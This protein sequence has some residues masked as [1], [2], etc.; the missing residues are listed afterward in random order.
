[1]LTGRQFNR[2]YSGR[3]YKFT[4][5]LENHNGIQYKS[6]LNHD[7]LDFDPS[8]R[9]QPG[10]LYFTDIDNIHIWINDNKWVREVMIPSNAS[11]YVENR[12]FKVDYFILGERKPV[13]KI[14][15]SLNQLFDIY[16]FGEHSYQT[17][18]TEHPL[19]SVRLADKLKRPISVF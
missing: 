3:F 1:M 14:K 7:I 17:M 8:G 13:P 18:F 16:M 12:K 4:N 10:G 9:C 6:G 11:V 5:L 15:Y 19:R 2:L